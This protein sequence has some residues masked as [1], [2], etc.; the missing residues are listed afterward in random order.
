M[1]RTQT[2]RSGRRAFEWPFWRAQD[3]AGVSEDVNTAT[4]FLLERGISKS[5][6]SC[7]RPKLT[8]HDVETSARPQLSFTHTWSM[9]TPS[10]VQV[11]L[12]RA[13]G[14]QVSTLQTNLFPGQAHFRH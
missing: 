11:S 9:L 10:F 8:C 12:V 4:S 2:H 13:G 7:M 3:L 14:M 1:A 6:G 5:S